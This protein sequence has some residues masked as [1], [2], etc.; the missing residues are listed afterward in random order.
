MDSKDKIII[1]ISAAVASLSMKLAAL[2]EK[3]NEL[4]KS[5]GDCERVKEVNQALSPKKNER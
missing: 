5:T 1:E 3:V 2:Q 4:C